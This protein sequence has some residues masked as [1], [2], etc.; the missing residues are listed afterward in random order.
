MS[1]QRSSRYRSAGHSAKATL[2][3]TP[4]RFWDSVLQN[5]QQH[6]SQRRRRMNICVVG[7]G[8]VGLVTGAGFAETGNHVTCAD[9]DERK[10][11]ELQKGHIPIFEPGL[12]KLVATNVEHGRLAFTT[13]VASA[14]K[15]AQ[16]IF[17]AVGTPPREDGS[18]DLKA[19]DTIAETIAKTI[20]Q[21][22]IVVLKS[23]VPVGTNARVRRIV[24]EFTQVPVHVV[25]NPEFLKEG[26]AVH[27][28]MHPDRIVLGFD[29]EE[30]EVQQRVRQ[31]MTRLYHP[32]SLGRDRIHWMGAASAELTKY[33]SNTMLAMRIS[34]M[35][36]IALL[37]ERVGA[38]AAHVR[39]AVGADSRIG[40]K[41]LHAGPGYGGSCFPKDIK[42]LLNTGR[43]HGLELELVGATHRVNQRQKVALLRKVHAHFDGSLR[44]RRIAVWGLTFKPRTD[45]IRESPAIALIESL[46]AE[47]AVISAHDPQGG[48]AAK[49]RFGDAVHVFDDCYQAADGAELLVLTTEWRE[50]QN[51]DF[52]KLKRLLKRPALIDARNIWASYELHNEGFVYEGIGIPRVHPSTSQ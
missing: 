7:T 49:R 46:L 25:S 4:V 23:T 17:I 12:D 10:I 20:T 52:Q 38:N 37:C 42:A 43:Q 13:D 28:F 33:V 44:G 35:N 24:R 21:E 19:V 36:E 6:P 5:E 30:P 16:I 8:Y 3:R 45:D 18:A 32:L 39:Q 29:G 40:E 47:S 11:A 15:Q 26:D 41:F 1:S 9:I 50:Y 14:M 51:P 34:F 48:D 27:D 2:A 22:T 31:T